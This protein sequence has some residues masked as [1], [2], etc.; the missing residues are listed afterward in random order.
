MSAAVNLDNLR[1]MTGGDAEIEREL[2]EVFFDSSEECLAAL[3][4]NCEDAGQ[5]SW[6]KQAH[7]WKGISLNL[8]AEQ[9]SKLCKIAQENFTAPA[10]EKLRMIAELQKEYEQVKEFLHSQL[11]A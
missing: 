8:G 1:D 10:E 4:S 6:R 3:Q 5:D 9:L 7:A 2:F 11:A